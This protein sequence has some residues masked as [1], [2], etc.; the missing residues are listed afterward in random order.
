MATQTSSNRG[1]RISQP[2]QLE[3]RMMLSASPSTT[4]TEL[5]AFY[6]TQVL[7]QGAWSDGRFE[8]QITGTGVEFTDTGLPDSM[9]G[10]IHYVMADGTV[11]ENVGTYSETL[12]PI[13]MDLDG[14]QTPES[15]VGT[16][17]ISTLS[18]YAG[19]MRDIFVGTIVTVNTS[20]IQGVVPETGELLVGSTGTIS[21]CSGV[22][23]HMVGTFTSASTVTLGPAFAMSTTVSFVIQECKL[24]G[25]F[26]SKVAKSIVSDLVESRIDKLKARLIDALHGGDDDDGRGKHDKSDKHDKWHDH[27]HSHR[28]DKVVKHQSHHDHSGKSGRLDRWA[29]E[30][31][32]WRHG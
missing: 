25:S 15:F 3:S 26:V 9:T 11:L 32:G 5:A 4:D 13:M 24:D 1:Y 17:G 27:D 2:E 16:N 12:T 31:A 6:S 30:L 29:S 20:F 8:L 10:I 19:K 28:L 23:K 14:D 7:K 22:F 18:F 21:A